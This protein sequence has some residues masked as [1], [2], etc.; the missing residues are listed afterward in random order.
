MRKV[1]STTLL[2]LALAN[3]AAALT[4]IDPTK[5]Y[6]YDSLMETRSYAQGEEMLWALSGIKIKPTGKTAILN[7]KLVREGDALDGAHIIEINPAEVILLRDQQRFA[8][9]L[10]IRDIK[11]PASGA[12]DE[13]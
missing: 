7:G 10:L 5:P 9:K 4:S 6:E 11:S 3:A 12:T 13:Q 2:S 1:F 8:V